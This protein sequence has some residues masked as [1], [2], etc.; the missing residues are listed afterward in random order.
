MFSHDAAL[1]MSYLLKKPED[2]FYYNE[3][4]GLYQV[5]WKKSKI[6]DSIFCQILSETR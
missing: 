5:D 6:C 2:R 1:F 4:Q 3:A